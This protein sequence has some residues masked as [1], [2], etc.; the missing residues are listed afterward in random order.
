MKLEPLL[1]LL[2]IAPISLAATLSFSTYWRVID[3][4]KA[5]PDKR[6]SPTAIKKPAMIAATSTS[7]EIGHRTRKAGSYESRCGCK[8]QQYEGLYHRDRARSNHRSSASHLP[9]LLRYLGTGERELIADQFGELRHGIA[10]K[11]RTFSW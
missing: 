5:P 11:Y 6:L 2:F 1:V 7:A 3:G 4:F 10:E 8:Q 9:C